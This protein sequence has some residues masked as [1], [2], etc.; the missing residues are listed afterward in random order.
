MAEAFV[1]DKMNVS[2][3]WD[4]LVGSS[5]LKKLLHAMVQRLDRHDAAIAGKAAGATAE[6]GFTVLSND[7]MQKMMDRIETLE[8]STLQQKLSDMGQNKTLTQLAQEGQSRFSLKKHVIPLTQLKGRV[9][10]AEAGIGI[11]SEAI[12]AAS[13]RLTET[14][15]VL[16]E[17]LER[18]LAKMVTKEEFKILEDKH[19]ALQE[20]VDKMMK[21]LVERL[22]RMIKEVQDQVDILKDKVDVAEEKIERALEEI[23]SCVADVKIIREQVESLE[24]LM[25]LKA[26]RAEL[27]AAIQEIKDELEAM[28]IEEIMAMAEKANQRI[29]AMDERVDAMEDDVRDLREYVLRK[30]KEL[31]DL[32][33][34]KQIEILRRELEEAKSGV[35]MKAQARMDEMQAETDGLKTTVQDTQGRVQI[36]RENITDLE[37]ALREAGASINT[38]S[39]SGG[40]KALIERLQVDVQNLQERYAEAAQKEAMGLEHAEKTDLLV[41]EIQRTMTALESAKADK[42]SVDMQLQVKADKESVARDTE[43]NQRAVDS[44]LH[45][46]NAGT[47]GIQQLLEQQEGAIDHLDA[48]MADKLNKQD[49]EKLQDELRAVSAPNGEASLERSEAKF[50]G[51]G[52]SHEEAALMSRPIGQYN[53]L[54]CKAPIRPSHSNPIP[55]LPLLPSRK[56]QGKLNATYV[57]DRPLSAA[58]TYGGGDSLV[59]IHDLSPTRA[60]GG[61]HTTR[62]VY[63]D[64]PPTAGSS[65]VAS[66]SSKRQKDVVGN[67]GR[68]YRGRGRP[69]SAGKQ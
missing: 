31:E 68:V 12:D 64:R 2:I 47:Q 19:N 56:S 21:D 38:S 5:N 69:G 30:E 37:E 63:D 52:I 20:Q 43:A 60:V 39:K 10:A 11:N 40:T 26:D 17:T 32:Q 42:K 16:H 22:E 13:D 28:N 25:P 14:I 8:N 18:E 44:A 15:K 1:N 6:D 46:M 24:E 48:K 62:R 41:T 67:D 9:E 27:E 7:Q 23:K 4:E 49:L 53:C 66:G 29:D 55:A 57:P 59:E 34:E 50:G 58:P 3:P 51:Y 33:L 61:A 36:N 35:F 45:T 54:T 65:R